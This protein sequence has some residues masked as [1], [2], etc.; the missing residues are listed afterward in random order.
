MLVRCECFI[1]N[2]IKMHINKL[3]YKCNEPKQKKWH[4]NANTFHLVQLYQA[5]FSKLWHSSS[6]LHF[7]PKLCLNI[8]LPISHLIQS[9]LYISSPT[10]TIHIITYPATSHLLLHSD[11]HQPITTRQPLHH[12]CSLYTSFCILHFLCFI[13]VFIDH[14][15]TW[16][17]SPPY[18]PIHI[19]PF[20]FFPHFFPVPL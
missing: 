5:Q 14:Y 17:H 4:S 8:L 1:L 11:Y 19:T 3:K 6:I 9:D 18:R 15:T 2:E 7:L 12:I 16:I 10:W 13:L 20:D